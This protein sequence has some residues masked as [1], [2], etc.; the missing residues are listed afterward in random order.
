MENSA[1]E[2][3]IA[4]LE[5]QSA[6][7]FFV[8]YLLSPLLVL[9]VGAVMNYRVEQNRGEIE[10]AKSDIQRIDLAQKMIPILFAGNPDQA[11]ATQRL[12]EKV[13]DP[14]VAKEFKE[15]IAKYYKAKV[16]AD[17][18]KG[19]IKSAVETLTAAQSI[20]GQSADQVVQSVTQNQGN[21]ETIQRYTSKLQIASQ[22][23][24]EGFENLLAGKYDD[25]IESFQAS[26]DAYNSYHQVFELSKLLRSR[27]QELNDENKRR[28]IFQLI[29]DKY[30]YGAPP[31]LLNQLKIMA[32]Q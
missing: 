2:A 16:E 21:N 24:R 11:F 13:L 23:E 7:R 32:K 30:S 26:E 29:V 12:M 20:G 8:Q 25:A 19:D 14:E 1:L 10:R 17:L 22:K 6:S 18:K 4:K 27:R 28:E 3:R 9:A 15:V 5:K 31:D